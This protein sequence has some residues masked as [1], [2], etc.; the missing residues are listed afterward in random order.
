MFFL[1]LVAIRLTVELGTNPA[2]VVVAVADAC[3][4]F[5]TR[6]TRDVERAIIQRTFEIIKEV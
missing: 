5:E 3:D 2:L 4:H 6:F 1:L